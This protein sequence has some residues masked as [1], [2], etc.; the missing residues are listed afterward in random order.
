MVRAPS[1]SRLVWGHWVG[2]WLAPRP[3]GTVPGPVGG[4]ALVGRWAVGLGQG[5]AEATVGTDPATGPCEIVQSSPALPCPV[6][7]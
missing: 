1:K 6:C 7:G 3:L 5:R 4:L 2:P